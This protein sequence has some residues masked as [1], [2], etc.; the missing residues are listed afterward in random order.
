MV[1]RVTGGDTLVDTTDVS[2]T[3][4]YTIPF[5]LKCAAAVYAKWT[6]TT[7]TGSIIL[8]WS[9]NNSD[10]VDIGSSADINAVLLYSAEIANKGY[11][12]LRVKV[13]IGSG[14]L[15]TLQIYANTKG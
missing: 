6:K 14:K 1:D 9:A 3:T 7:V 12:Y 13:T 10:W 4:G 11:K 2:A 5:E 8:Q 15:D